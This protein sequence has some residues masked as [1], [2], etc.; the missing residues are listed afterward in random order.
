MPVLPFASL[1]D[2]VALANDTEYGL[3][4]SV[5]SKDV[6]A[7]KK[8][9]IQINA[10]AIGINDGSMT[11]AVH[12]VEKNS[13][14]NSG[15]GASRMGSAGFLRFFRSRSLLQQTTAPMSLTLMAEENRPA[16]S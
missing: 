5:F 9:A 11:A 7:A 1:E 15:M 14:L 6:D 16:G 8:V 10:G 2:A 13:F 12:D 4:A 3:S